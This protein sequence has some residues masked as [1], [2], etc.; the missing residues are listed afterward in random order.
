MKLA[1]NI[2]FLLIFTYSFSQ[3]EI[4]YEKALSDINNS[5]EI[6]CTNLIIPNKYFSVGIY[7]EQ[8][9]VEDL[10]MEQ[11]GDIKTD[12]IKNSK[13]IKVLNSRNLLTTLYLNMEN[14]EYVSINSSGKFDWD[15]ANL[16]VELNFTQI[17][18][19][20]H[21][22]YIPINNKKTAKEIIT[23]ISDIFE[24]DYCFKKLKRNL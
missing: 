22:V 14:N 9:E 11:C 4:T 10:T 24:S 15:K 19:G 16:I 23:S 5:S 18:D 2:F 13:I 8:W 12:S 21:Q 17:W 3:S 1:I 20:I 6:L 7:T